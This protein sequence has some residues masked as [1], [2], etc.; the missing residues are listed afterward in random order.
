MMPA[1][2]PTVDTGALLRLADAADL[3]GRFGACQHPITLTGQRLLVDADTGQILS[4]LDPAGTHAA[5]RCRSRRAAACPACS[6]LYRLD[7][8]HLIAAGLRGGKATPD[9]VATRPRLFVTLTAPSFG[10][11]H[12]GPDQHGGPRCCHPRR[13]GRWHRPGD[14]RIGTP[15]DAARYDYAGQVLF[16][17]HAGLLW[18]RLC[19]DIRRAL[20]DAAGVSRTDAAATVRVVFAKVAEFQARGVVH[21]HAVM[22]LDGT[23]GPHTAP[24]GWATTAALSAAIRTAASRTRLSTPAVGTRAA[25]LLR[26]GRQLDIQHLNNGG[27][28]DVA[29]ASYVAKYATKTA[30]VTGVVLAP[31]YCRACGGHGTRPGGDGRV[32]RWC[33][34]CS[35]TGRRRGVD[36]S[37]L[38]QHPRALVDTCWRLGGLPAFEPLRLRRWAHQLGYRGH[39]TTKSRSYSTT[40]GALRGE[41][42][43]WAHQHLT[44]HLGIDPDTPVIVVGDWRYTG[45]APGTPGGAP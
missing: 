29:V 22:R 17:A 10:P 41:R 15:I 45:P 5:V 38:G 8:Y 3:E 37:G 18:A 42:R 19:I 21:F 27:V 44:Q 4:R 1:T 31:L 16:N 39:V 43:D 11:V 23:A 9:A 7:A 20:A 30:E 12:L 34:A 32:R 35:G 36:L 25:R 14:P 28:S 2:P 13:C 40:F 24:P 6:A 33:R 26:F